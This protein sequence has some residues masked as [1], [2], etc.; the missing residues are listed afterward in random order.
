MGGPSIIARRLKDNH[1]QYGWSGN[2]GYYHIVGQRLLEWYQSADMVEYLFGLGQLRFLGAPGSEHGGYSLMLSHALDG[3]PHYLGTTERSIFSKIA[4]IDYGYFYD[5][6]EK[7]YYINPGPFRIKL[8]LELVANN[9]DESG[10]EFS[11]LDQIEHGITD[12]IFGEY[13]SNDPDFKNVVSKYDLRVVRTALI[14]SN[15]PMHMLYDKY[16]ELYNYFDDWIV[17]LTDQ[18]YKNMTGV[19]AKPRGEKHI[20]TIEWIASGVQ[21]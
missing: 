9:L 5:L 4:F 17:V 21:P 13:L 6:D 3:M 12:Y 7:W 1:V 16:R 11:F 10:Y 15:C 20:E 2:G 18:E 14:S 8:P 19:I